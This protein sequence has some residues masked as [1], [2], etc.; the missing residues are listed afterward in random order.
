[1]VSG[2]HCL[3]IWDTKHIDICQQDE[4]KPYLTLEENL[5]QRIID[6]CVISDQRIGCGCM[7]TMIKIWNVANCECEFMMENGYQI[8]KM[9]PMHDDKMICWSHHSENIKIWEIEKKTNIPMS[10][11]FPV[12]HGN[13]KQG[14]NMFVE[15]YIRWKSVSRIQNTIKIFDTVKNCQSEV[16]LN[17]NICFD[18]D[19]LILPDLRM[20][21]ASR[22]KESIMIWD[23]HGN[24][25]MV[26]QTNTDMDELWTWMLTDGRII[27]SPSDG[28]IKI[29]H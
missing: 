14:S 24:N 20:M 9:I 2:S 13:G 6:I 15:K 17:E 22:E 21:G 11:C 16:E 18:T 27:A 25:D 10:G 1:M 23:S 5:E 12:N 26:L 29:W 3:R 4:M 19:F 8:D 7:D 28:G